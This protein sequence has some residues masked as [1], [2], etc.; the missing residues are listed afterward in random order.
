MAVKPK[1]SM[2]DFGVKSVQI[3]FENSGLVKGKHI[4]YIDE[5]GKTIVLDIDWI[6]FGMP[7]KRPL[8]GKIT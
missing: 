3:E 8:S 5:Y 1:I 7:E 4:L 6:S 2:G